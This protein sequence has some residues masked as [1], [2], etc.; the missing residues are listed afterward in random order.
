MLKQVQ[1][2][3]LLYERETNSKMLEFKVRYLHS[4]ASLL[5]TYFQNLNFDEMIQQISEYENG[6][7]LPIILITVLI[8][9][10]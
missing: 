6:V 1:S 8:V 4:Y 7:G 5:E 3:D 10:I 2:L 9:E